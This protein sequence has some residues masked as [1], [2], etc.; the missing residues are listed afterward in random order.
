MEHKRIVYLLHGKE[1]SPASKKLK[2]L[3][4]LAENKGFHTQSPDYS[5][6]E[7]PDK[8]VEDFLEL[9]KSI[10]DEIV[11]FGSSMGAYVATVASKR[12]KPKGLF[13][14][15]PAFYIESYIHQDPK[16]VAEM[17]SIIHGWNDEIVPVEHSIRFAQKYRVDLHL[18]NGD[19]RL[20]DHL[21]FIESIF[22]LFLDQLFGL[23]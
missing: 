18:I 16:P 12:L 1:S 9:S 20:M 13:L 11:L 5:N 23:S 10:D 4:S 6:I 17:T 21:S 8:R 14:L 2:R 22:S 7:D 3:A 15:A 19:H